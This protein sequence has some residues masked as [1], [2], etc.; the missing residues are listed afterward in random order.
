MMD[1][2]LSQHMDNLSGTDRNARYESYQ[3][4]LNTSNER[5]SWAYAVWDKL[6]KMLKS[7]DNHLRTI[8]VQ[9]L[10]NLAKS[11]PENRILEDLDQLIAVTKDERF[12][13]A[14]HSLQSL[15]RAGSATPALQTLILNKLTDRFIGAMEEKNGTLI[16]YDIIEVFK[17]I[18]DQTGDASL[19]KS[20]LD[21]IEIETDMKYRKKYSGLWK[22]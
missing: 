15:W 7:N 21:L 16:R 6:L 4:L 12:V 10:S 1:S 19:K 18:Y 5:V 8:A 17:K 13:T 22:K 20:A 3:Y 2:L 9:I 14:R 11:D